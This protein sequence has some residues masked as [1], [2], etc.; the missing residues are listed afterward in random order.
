MYSGQL[1][2]QLNLHIILLILFEYIFY[3][4]LLSINFVT[5]SNAK[6]YI[7]TKER[8]VTF[9]YFTSTKVHTKKPCI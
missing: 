2:M 6:M 4:P 5:F 1:C 3:E 7:K 8:N 9:Y